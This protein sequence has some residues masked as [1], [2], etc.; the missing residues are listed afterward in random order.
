M[1][2]RFCHNFAPMGLVVDEFTKEFL[3]RFIPTQMEAYKSFY[4]KKAPSGRNFGRVIQIKG[5]SP[6]GAEF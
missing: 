3:I 6:I 1:T 5:V 4:I 2:L